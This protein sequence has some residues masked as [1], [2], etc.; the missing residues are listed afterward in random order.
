MDSSSLWSLTC[1]RAGGAA[2]FEPLNTLSSALLLVAAWLLWRDSRRGFDGE[3]AAAVAAVALMGAGGI[4]FHG[5]GGSWTIYADLLPVAL[6]ATLA[7]A[8]ALL[9][10]LGCGDRAAALWLSA[11]AGANALT[12]AVPGPYRLNDSVA[13]LPYL[14]ALVLTGTR[15]R[16]QHHSAAPAVLNSAGLF[17][18]AL[19]SRSIDPAVCQSV[20]TGSYWLWHVTNAL[21]AYLLVRAIPEKRTA[22]LAAAN[23]SL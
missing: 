11:F 2:T 13:Y 5:I 22:L 17:A 12:N 23:T 9:R 20:P 19:V 16:G 10:L 4:I 6:F 7:L 15:L 18:L 1:E 3:R 8:L 21:S 14:I